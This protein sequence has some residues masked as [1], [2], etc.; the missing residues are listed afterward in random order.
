[1]THQLNVNLLNNQVFLMNFLSLKRYFGMS[2][3]NLNSDSSAIS[4]KISKTMYDISIE[5]KIVK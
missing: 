4:K 2:R 1:M 3:S 5:Y